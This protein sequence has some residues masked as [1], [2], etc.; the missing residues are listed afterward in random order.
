MSVPS[1]GY[2]PG[3]K[4]QSVHHLVLCMSQTPIRQSLLSY[5]SASDISLLQAL[6]C[7]QLSETESA[8]YLN[9]V[10][11]LPTCNWLLENIKCRDK[12][13]LIGDDVQMLLL[14]IQNPISYHMKHSEKILKIWTA[15]VPTISI[16]KP[17]TY[18][19]IEEHTRKVYRRKFGQSTLGNNPVNFLFIQN[20]YR[21]EMERFNPFATAFTLS[22]EATEASIDTTLSMD[23][24]TPVE[25]WDE[26]MSGEVCSDTKT[27]VLQ[28]YNSTI[29]RGTQSNTCCAIAYRGEYASSLLNVRYENTRDNTGL[30]ISTSYIRLH[31][32]PFRV[33]T[34]HAKRDISKRRKKVISI[35]IDSYDERNGTSH[36]DIFRISIPLK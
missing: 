13:I 6:K 4:K 20:V 12:V 21:W 11:D 35:Q 1:D 32:D 25:G 9:L 24:D 5:C 34:S 2:G 15:V 23:S 14:R 36:E 19:V 3:Y 26:W 22:P 33:F 30:S 10:R 18:T 27:D 7:M 16:P 17:G 8:R 31:N 29:G 28:Y